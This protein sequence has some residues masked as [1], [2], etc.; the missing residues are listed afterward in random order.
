MFNNL[1]SFFTASQ[2][3]ITA[4]DLWANKF[5]PQAIADHLCYKCQNHHEFEQLREFFEKE[6]TFIYQSIISQRRIAIIKFS[7]PL[8]TTLGKIWYLELS[9]QKPDDSQISDFDH[10]EIYPTEG[11]VEKLAEELINKGFNLKKVERPHHTTFDGF[12]NENLKIRLEPEA[13]IE[14][15]KKQEIV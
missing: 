2:T 6:S 3:T 9:D 4:F 13:L 5:S 7:Q 1:E 10:L 11:T 12:I 8:I 15:I 14:K